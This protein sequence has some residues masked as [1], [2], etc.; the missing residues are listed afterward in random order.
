MMTLDQMRLKKEEMGLSYTDIAR[1]S[2]VPLATVQKVLS[3]ITK[4]PRYQT[5]LDLE[6]VFTGENV[7]FGPSDAASEDAPFRIAGEQAGSKIPEA[8]SDRISEEGKH[9]KGTDEGMI[10][11][12]AFAIGRT[13]DDLSS[14]TDCDREEMKN[15]RSTELIRG[16]LFDQEV[17][18]ILHQAFLF[19]IASYLREIIHK[20]NPEYALM[21]GPMDLALTDPALCGRTDTIVQPDIFVLGQKAQIRDGRIDQVPAFVLEVLSEKTRLKDLTLKY[22]VYLQAGVHEYWCLDP[23]NQK[24]IA[25]NL[26]AI[27]AKINTVEESIE[28]N[29][30]D[31]EAASDRKNTSDGNMAHGAEYSFDQLIPLMITKGEYFVDMKTVKEDLAYLGLS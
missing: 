25:Y 5:R 28:K 10:R 15:A 2:G 18:G 19:E 21:I 26:D 31:R 12:L 29:A 22:L 7:P 8:L 4:S 24:V 23:A 11:A 3:G 14:Y 27:R 16:V 9:G 1:Q 13:M 20:F 6:R 30:A 17:P